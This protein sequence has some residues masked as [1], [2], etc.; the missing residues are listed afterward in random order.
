MNELARQRTCCDAPSVDRYLPQGLA[1]VTVLVQQG[2]PVSEKLNGQIIIPKH[3]QQEVTVVA[4]LMSAHTKKRSC[5][6]CC[7]SKLMGQHALVVPSQVT[8]S[9]RDCSDPSDRLLR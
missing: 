7:C 6:E 2:Q 8:I 4:N 3:T 1:V 5:E 9:P